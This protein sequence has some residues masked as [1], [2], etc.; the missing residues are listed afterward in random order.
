MTPL[1]TN[2]IKMLGFSNTLQTAKWVFFIISSY[3][4]EE[5]SHRLTAYKLHSAGLQDTEMALH[6][7]ACSG[8]GDWCGRLMSCSMPGARLA[9]MGEG[10]MQL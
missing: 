3:F 8:F 2:E 7:L 9:S 5:Q 4:P 10:W 1:G 6:K